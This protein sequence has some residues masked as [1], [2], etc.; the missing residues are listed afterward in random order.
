MAKQQNL[1]LWHWK[2]VGAVFLFSTF[3]FARQFY[4]GGFNEES[5]RLAIRWSARISEVLFSMAFVA[6]SLQ[7]FW[8][9]V[10][11]FWMRMNRKYLGISFAMSHLFHLGWLVVLQQNF[12]PVFDRAKTISLIG[13]GLAY[14]FLVLMLLTSFPFFAKKISARN[15]KILHTAGGWWIWY[16]FIRS[17]GKN[18]I[19]KGNMNY[20]PALVMLVAV[21]LFRLAA[22]WKK[23]Q[24]ALA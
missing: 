8:G 18:V 2:L 9:N 23:R 17:V 6:A 13:G 24:K 4:T 5:T 16:I 3:L 21:L 19:V 12:H 20:F 11:T 14:L 10:F 7:Y 1:G 22:R 15:W